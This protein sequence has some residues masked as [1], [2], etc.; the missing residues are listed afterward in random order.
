MS[1]LDTIATI[2]KNGVI[3]INGLAQTNAR[4]L[5]T[6]TSSVITSGT[7]VLSGAGYLVRYSI[8]VAGSAGTINNAAS[9]SA[10]APGNALCVTQATVGIYNV[11]IPFTNGLVVNPGSGQSVVVVY[12]IG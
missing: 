4:G 10:S 8:L 1:S 3:A 12:S 2:Q 7:L 11:G 6:T 9:T 5:G